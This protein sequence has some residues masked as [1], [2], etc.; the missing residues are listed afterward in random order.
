MKLSLITSFGLLVLFYFFNNFMLPFGL[1]YS[2]ILSPFMFYY[3]KVDN[4]LSYLK[5]PILIVF[6]FSVIHFI[7]GVNFSSF[8]VSIILAILLIIYISAFTNFYKKTDYLEFYFE[9]LTQF[10]FIFTCIAIVSLFFNK[11]VT[12]FWYLV[13]F[14]PGHDPIPRLKLFET[15]ASVYSFVLLPLFF[16]Y[17]W[18]ILTNYTTKSFLLFL[19]LVLSLIMSFSMGVMAVVI[20][21]ICFVFITFLIKIIK[22]KPTRQSILILILLFSLGF[23]LTYLFYPNNPLFF[24]IENI[25]S[26]ADTSGRGRT[27]ESFEIAWLTL[28]ENN[29]FFGVGMGQFKI[30]GRDILIF[31]YKFMGVPEIARIPNGMAETLITFGVL[32]FILRILIQL[33]LFVKCKVYTNIFQ[34]S[35]FYAVFIYQFTGSHLLNEIE[36]VLWVIIF[37]PKFNAFNTLFYFKS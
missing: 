4:N 15:E 23:I 8:I 6:S 20:L 21:S 13:P 35:L 22:F 27:Y 9:K 36:Y 37:I 32:G 25:I 26:G 34:L 7:L 30:I 14:T 16:Y 19:S 3:L 11:L 31:Y 17:F 24:R 12:V 28:K 5:L 10:N 33:I 18:T 2:I 29:Y 1:K